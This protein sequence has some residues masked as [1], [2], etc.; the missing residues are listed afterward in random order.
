MRS[1]LLT[2]ALLATLAG[3][4]CAADKIDVK[5]GK[6]LHDK[7]CVNCHVQRWG[8]DGS[9][10]YT[11]ADRKINDAT[12]LRQRVAACSAQTGA[13]FFPEDEAN[14]AAWLAQTYYKFK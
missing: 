11:R 3:A 14:V 12:S 1:P 7:Q 2:A 10:V 8:G 13:K 4:A 5:A 6:A 9:A